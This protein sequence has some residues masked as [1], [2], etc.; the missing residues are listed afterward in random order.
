MEKFN[1][2]ETPEVIILELNKE[3]V[4]ATSIGDSG[5]VEIDW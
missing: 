4:I 1:K 5:M 3:D 2:Y